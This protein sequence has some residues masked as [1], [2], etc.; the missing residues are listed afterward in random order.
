MVPEDICQ[1]LDGPQNIFPNSR[2]RKILAQTSMDLWAIYPKVV[3]GGGVDCTQQDSIAN[4]FVNFYHSLMGIA[5][6]VS[7]LN[8]EWIN[9]SPT[10]TSTQESMLLTP[11]TPVEIKAALFNM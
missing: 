6:E 1:N 5:I 2:V 9:A 8:V 11:F 3:D 10:L 4:A 7:P